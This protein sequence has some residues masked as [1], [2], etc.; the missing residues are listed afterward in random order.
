MS[1]L[2]FKGRISGFLTT[3]VERPTKLPMYRIRTN[4]EVPPVANIAI[5]FSGLKFVDLVLVITCVCTDYNRCLF[6]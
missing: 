1:P 4:A 2:L 3:S 6:C 5:Y